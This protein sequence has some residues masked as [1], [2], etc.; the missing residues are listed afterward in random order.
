VLLGASP[1][2]SPVA[3]RDTPVAQNRVV[4]SL[5]QYQRG[6]FDNAVNHL[7]GPR[8]VRSVV[9]EFRSNA[10]AW[11]DRAPV[12]DR[13]P[14]TLV[15]AA[16]SVEIMA[17][18]FLQHFFDYGIA[19]E[20]VEWSC[21]RLKKFPPVD[22]E[23]WVHLSFIALAQGARDDSLLTGVRVAIGGFL[24]SPGAHALHAGVRFPGEGRFKLALATG[25]WQAQMIATF[26]LTPYYLTRTT[27]GRFTI[28]NHEKQVLDATLTLLAALFEDP[29]VGPEARLRSGVLKFVREDPA[30]A[31]ED[32]LRAATSGDPAVRSI[33]HLMLGT[34]ADS[35]DNG[36]EALRRFRLAYDAVPSSA[37]SVALATR[38][39]RSGLTD[40][41]TNV[42]ETFEAAPAG[43]DPWDLYGQR[44]FRFFGAYKDQMRRA[45][46]K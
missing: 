4:E 10:G 27:A 46:A 16:M 38:L 26:P 7:I 32:L 1:H 9:G 35:V 30:A 22:A 24:Y 34:L 20:L 42:L 12:A 2:G 3:F 39:Y 33:A 29:G 25:A 43:P 15:A 11:I 13:H 6:E 8:D 28:D 18:S 5:E 41:A 21:S 17:A 37:S 40:E 36:Q 44:D 19:R 14:R 45:V 31:R 23:R